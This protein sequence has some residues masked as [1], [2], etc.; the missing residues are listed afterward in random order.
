MLKYLPFSLL[1]VPAICFAQ[2]TVP[3]PDGAGEKIV[4][5]SCAGCHSIKVVTSKHASHEE[6]AILVDQM[7]TR[8][9]QV[10]DEDFDVLVDYLATNFGKA[11]IP[12][13]EPDASKPGTVKISKAPMPELERI[14]SLAKTAL[15][16][17]RA[18][19]Q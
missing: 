7:V 4:R 8:G 19:S 3:L 15:S 17:F 9:A 14:L 18:P 10:S 6:W 16:P 13:E 2:T 5:K 11:K 12:S 1:L